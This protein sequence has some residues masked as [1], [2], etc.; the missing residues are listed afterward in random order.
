[1]TPSELEGAGP[2]GTAPN[3]LRRN[4]AINL[5]GALAPLLLL[6]VTVPLYLGIVGDARYGVLVVVSVLLGYF[7]AFDLGLGRA[8]ANQ[9]ATM[10][11]DRAA[12][13]SAVL[14]T[15]LLLNL[16][17][18]GAAAILLFFVADLLIGTVFKIP[19]ELRSEALGA[20]PW[21]AAAVPLATTSSVLRGALEG[22]ERFV[23]ANAVGL[24]G[25]ALFQLVPLAI[26]YVWGPNL[27][28]LIAGATIATLV[29]TLATFVACWEYVRPA[30]SPRFDR[31]RARQLLRYGG[32]VN[33]TGAVGPLLNVLD[34]LVIAAALGA[35]AV[36]QYTVPFTLVA[37]IDILPSSVARA[38]FPRFSAL[39]GD[40]AAALGRRALL[41]L[42]AIATPAVVLGVILVEPFLVAWVGPDLA[43]KAAPVAAILLLGLWLNGLAHIPFALLQ[44]Q[45]R[46][47]VPAKLHLLELPP[48]LL[49]LWLGL[50]LFGVEGAAWAW[51]IRAAADAAL[52]FWASR[53]ALKNL[54][55]LAPA[56][57]LVVLACVGALTIFSEPAVRVAAGAALVVL[58]LAWAWRAAPRTLRPRFRRTLAG[59]TVGSSP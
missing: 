21:M 5:A 9:I 40:E 23:A 11:G 1:M 8:T 15:A 42:A 47:D 37:R 41:G 27:T 54:L 55:P 38:L 43:E 19:A 36:T 17:F 4:T 44:A 2:A 30:T 48:Y 22:R 16:A 52:L 3:S 29:T 7:G 24:L 45:G 26:A 35:R 25:I 12:D 50:S 6:V 14:W 10:D 57:G 46:P 31:R 20:L 49:A 39:P 28:W 58:A 34:R 59:V 32:C 56:L 13:R 53:V 18:T 33:V 51:S